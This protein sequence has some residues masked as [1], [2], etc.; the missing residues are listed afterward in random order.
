[1]VQYAKTDSTAVCFCILHH[2]GA[3][4]K[5]KIESGV[6]C[7][8]ADGYHTNGNAVLATIAITISMDQNDIFVFSE[9]K[10]TQF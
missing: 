4:D 2:L 1:M 7:S 9:M 6:V 10:H 5:I 3:A 8:F